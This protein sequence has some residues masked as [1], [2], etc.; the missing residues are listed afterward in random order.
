MSLVN[1]VSLEWFVFL[2]VH[3]FSVLPFTNQVSKEGAW[4]FPEGSVVQTSC[5]YPKKCG[6]DPRVEKTPLEENMATPLHYSA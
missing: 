4:G 2:Q 1:F 6:F 5:Q 3:Y